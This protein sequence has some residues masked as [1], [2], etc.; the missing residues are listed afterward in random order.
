[1]KS[2][3]TLAAV[4]VTSAAM[5]LSLASPAFAWEP[6]GKIVKEVQ[7]VTQSSQLAD[8]NTAEQAVA[9]KPG[10]TLKYVITVR[11]D[12]KADSRGWNDMYY[13][14]VVDQLP[15]GLELTDGQAGKDLG[16]IKAKDSKSYSFTVKVTAQQDNSVI[17]NTAKFTG[18]SEIRDRSQ[19][20]EDKACV[21]VSVP[22]APEEPEVP[23]TPEEPVTPEVP[24]TPVTPEEPEA[25]KPETPVG[26]GETP[27]E[28]PSTGPGAALSAI[29]GAGSLAGATSAYLR[30]R[31]LVK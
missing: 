14:K 19:S 23:V 20:G 24:E 25:P 28:I 1:M 26:K 22:P 29:L 6:Q 15:E 16:V 27:K 30:S 17:C 13:T 5:V 9:A 12:G 18:D 11:N 8:A 7:N 21:K 31:R 2:G 3:T 10:D 4:G